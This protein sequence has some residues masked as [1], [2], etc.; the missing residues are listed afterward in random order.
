M[1]DIKNILNILTIATNELKSRSSLLGASAVI[2]VFPIIFP[3]LGKML[4]LTSDYADVGIIAYAILLC[5]GIGFSVLA[6]SSLLGTDLTNRRMSF[7]FVRPLSTVNVFL[8]K[9]LGAFTLV[10]GSG[11]ITLLPSFIFFGNS[12]KQFLTLEH[13]T[14]YGVISIFFLGLGIVAGIIFRSKS[15]ILGLDLALIPVA[16]VLGGLAFIR[17]II[18]YQGSYFLE[19]IGLT[20]NFDPFALI[21][22]FVGVIMIASSGIGLAF[23]RTDIKKVHR[24]LS[25]GLWGL[26][27]ALV[28]SGFTFSQWIVSASPKDI[29]RIYSGNVITGDNWLFVSG[30]AW[31]RGS[32]IPVFLLNFKNDSYI[33]I[34]QEAEVNISKDGSRVVWI[35]R[36][37]YLTGE[38]QLVKINLKDENAKPIYTNISFPGYVSCQLSNDGS[39]ALVTRE[40][41]VTIFDLNNGD[42]ELVTVHIPSF[43]KWPAKVFF[44]NSDVIRLYYRGEEV[45][46]VTPVQIFELQ[47]KDKKLTQVGQ[48]SLS[49]YGYYFTISENGEKLTVN[50]IVFNAKTGEELANLEKKPQIIGNTDARKIQFINNDRFV[51]ID[52]D[53]DEV[54]LKVFSKDN[55]EEQEISLGKAYS[56]Y[57]SGQLSDDELIVNLYQTYQ[58]VNTKYSVLSVN[59]KTKAIVVKAENLKNLEVSPWISMKD[60]QSKKIYRVTSKG[61][62]KLDLASG[63]EEVIEKFS[64]AE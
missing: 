56:A 28:L 7:Y 64:I 29:T 52:S 4:G 8:G 22:A 47:I 20:R 33:R 60:N 42:K 3:A 24:A 21:I 62:V 44:L 13:M 12:T 49:Q 36:K 26:M 48:F 25:T 59:L 32:H 50:N 5:C 15:Y 41:L 34:P 27:M 43:S 37:G 1:K 14:V 46:R 6:G 45:D 19:Q 51:V 63:Q 9:L 11:V 58:P 40:K 35:E 30:K 39:L 31:G 18:A 23:G 2:A 17:I 57:I 61:L 16:L 38:Q 54:T 55:V 53:T 10:F